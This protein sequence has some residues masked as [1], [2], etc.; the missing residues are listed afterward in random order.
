MANETTS[1]DA[2]RTEVPLVAGISNNYQA[3]GMTFLQMLRR[4]RQEC[5]VTGTEPTSVSNLPQEMARLANYIKQS[6]MDIQTLHEDWE[7]LRQPVQFVTAADKQ[8]YSANEMNIASF[9][10]L[11]RDSFSISTL[12]ENFADEVPL[13]FMDFERFKMMF[14]FGPRRTQTSRPAVWTSD[15]QGN[16]LL[17]GTPDKQY[18]VMGESYAMPT[19]L[20]NNDDRPACPPQYHMAIVYKAMM[21]YA[22]FE[23][24]P[25]V[26]NAGRD[27]YT[28]LMAQMAAHQLPTMTFGAPLA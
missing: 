18:Q 4:L 20:V 13:D 27:G 22:L 3:G 8:K 26:H 14:M 1:P 25:E 24:A 19:E 21:K 17:G 10:V 2:A 12:G 11:K 15:S 28:P 23:A 6:W 5:G 16:L 7:F 9:N